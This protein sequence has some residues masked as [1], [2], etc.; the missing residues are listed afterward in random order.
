MTNEAL[1][2]LQHIDPEERVL[3]LPHCLRPSKGCRSQQTRRGLVC[4]DDCMERCTIRRL[5]QAALAQGY[6]GVC[7]AAGGAMA[8]RFVAE[9]QPLAIVAVACQKELAEGVQAVL[10]LGT[11]EQEAPTI[12]AVPLTRDGCVD[13]EVDEG[14]ALAAISMGCQA[15]PAAAAAAA[16]LAS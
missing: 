15:R 3:L 9:A 7:V 8:I 5:R 13:T 16:A 12:V 10:E 2:K 14:R 11:T 6:K 1:Q 4:P